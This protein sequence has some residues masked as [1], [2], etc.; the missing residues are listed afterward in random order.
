MN[1]LLCGRRERLREE[2]KRH[3]ARGKSWS[4]NGSLC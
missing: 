3:A 1:K 4:G 2:K